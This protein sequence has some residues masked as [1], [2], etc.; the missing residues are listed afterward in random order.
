M[1]AATKT[2]YKKCMVIVTPL[3]IY[4]YDSIKHN[5]VMA[6]NMPVQIKINTNLP[7]FFDFKCMLHFKSPLR[8]ASMMKIGVIKTIEN[9]KR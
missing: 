6:K 9:K 7:V 5:E 8:I 2:G 1:M 4:E 3:G